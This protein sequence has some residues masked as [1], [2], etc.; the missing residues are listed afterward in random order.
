MIVDNKILL[1]YHYVLIRNERPAL[2]NNALVLID[3]DNIVWMWDKMFG[4]GGYTKS[5]WDG[6]PYC[7]KEYK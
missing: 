7:V 5:L 1:L 3:N 6:L 2:F 4:R